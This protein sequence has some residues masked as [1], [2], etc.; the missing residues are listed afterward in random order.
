MHN[1]MFTSTSSDVE[2]KLFT[3]GRSESL[4]KL[5]RSEK[6]DISWGLGLNP[7]WDT[8]EECTL[9]DGWIVVFPGFDSCD[10][11]PDVLRATAGTALLTLVWYGHEL[12]QLQVAPSPDISLQRQARDPAV[13]T[14]SCCS[15]SV[16]QM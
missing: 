16:S 10:L 11:A 5:K 2:E 4:I 1:L 9:R 12:L 3:T 7:C 6:L 14:A 15:S 8:G 13:P